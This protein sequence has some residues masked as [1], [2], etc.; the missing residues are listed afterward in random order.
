MLKEGAIEMV[1]QREV[2][3]CTINVMINGK[4]SAGRIRM[5]LD[6]API[7]V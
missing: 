2:I 7:N 5:N 3:K 4:K 6:A 1:D